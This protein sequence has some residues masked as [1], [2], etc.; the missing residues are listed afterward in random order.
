[1]KL[2]YS[3]D[4]NKI[5][6]LPIL[7]LTHKEYLSITGEIKWKKI[8]K[9][10]FFHEYLKLKILSLINK[11][12]IKAFNNKSIINSIKIVHW[13]VTLNEPIP[14]IKK[15]SDVHLVDL[16]SSLSTNKYY[17]FPLT[18]PITS[19]DFEPENSFLEFSEESFKWD[20]IT[21]SHNSRR[22]CLDDCL[23]IIR[24][25]LDRKPDFKCLLII[26]TPSKSYR[27]NTLSSSIKFLKIYDELFTYKERQQIVLLRISDEMGLE[28]VSP[29][30]IKW[31]MVNSKI[32]LFASKKEGSAKVLTEAK[33]S[34][35]KI[36]SRKG[37]KGGSYDNLKKNF[38]FTWSKHE[39]A[40][41]KIL[42]L[43]KKT[44]SR[45]IRNKNQYINLCSVKKLENFLKDR[46]LIPNEH[47]LNKRDF[48]FANRWLPAHLEVR[49]TRG[50]TSDIDN[51]I[52]LWNYLRSIKTD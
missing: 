9:I 25:V 22:K 28:G 3:R 49:K 34:N 46:N 8:R 33:N 30:F 15:Y 50:V 10:I 37:L 48:E 32:F 13:G 19:K 26:N 4:S 38:F 12:M 5:K 6:S 51:P 16:K 41:S 47:T 39:E 31:S 2:I 43:L 44:K 18:L 45:N 23:Y 42:K 7:F 35:C 17:G 14:Y 29:S 11:L 27:K 52:K 24:R 36:V 21:V 20:V 40:S 1:M